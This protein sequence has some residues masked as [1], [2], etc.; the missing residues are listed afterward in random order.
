MWDINNPFVAQ[1][2]QCPVC[3]RVYSPSTPWCYF[4]G[5]YETKATTTASIEISSDPPNPI[6]ASQ[7]TGTSAFITGMSD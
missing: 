3:G 4:C 6:H 2:W 1:G 5:N 7:S